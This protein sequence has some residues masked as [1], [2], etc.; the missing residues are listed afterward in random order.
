MYQRKCPF[1][2]PKDNVDFDNLPGFMERG[3]IR[4]FHCI[5]RHIV[6]GGA[7]ESRNPL[8]KVA[9]FFLYF[10]DL[11]WAGA[12]KQYYVKRQAIFGPNYISTLSLVLSKYDPDANALDA[13]DTRLLKIPQRRGFFLGSTRLNRNRVPYG[14][15][16]G[17]RGYLV[18]PLH[19]SDPGATINPDLPEGQPDHNVLR[20]YLMD[21]VLGEDDKLPDILARC[22]DP[23]AQVLLKE[24]GEKAKGLIDK[25]SLSPILEDFLARYLTY[26]IFDCP[27]KTIPV[28]LLHDTFYKGGK[29][30]LYLYGPSWISR[31]YGDPKPVRDNL[32]K[33]CEYFSEHSSVLRNVQAGPSGL[34][35]PALLEMLNLIVGIAAFQGTK[36]LALTAM[37]QM[38]K[39]YAKTVAAADAAGSSKLRNAILECARLDT[40]VTGA[41]L[42]VDNADGLTTQIGGKTL[43]FRRGTVVF[44]GFTIANVDAK[45]FPN[46]FV[47][48]PEN[49][50]FSKLTSFNS[51]GESTNLQAPRICPGREIA[52]E[53]VAQLIKAKT[54]AE[55]EA[56][57]TCYSSINY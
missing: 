33:V 52:I 36:A 17:E 15:I 56:C 28:E 18:S 54:T 49:R 38:P 7:F 11:F 9:A 20:Q 4:V 24:F 37:V 26:V 5:S 43:T 42:I 50:D 39:G 31:I 46:P 40:P 29:Y 19:A 35:K 13:I 47:F 6:Q 32:D 22:S 44:T 27:I 45:R 10:I 25:D 8:M 48:D 41:H 1:H 51:V 55:A 12:D 2:A 3:A 57:L 30:V 14:T 53:T 23:K 16:N 21:N 34:D